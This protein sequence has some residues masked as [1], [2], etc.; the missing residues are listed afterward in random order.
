MILGTVNRISKSTGSEFGSSGT[1][2]DYSGIR[3]WKQRHR[4]STPVEMFE[5]FRFLILIT[6][7]LLLPPAFL[8]GLFTIPS[9]S[10][11]GNLPSEFGRQVADSLELRR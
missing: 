8:G 4:K 6:I 9:Q 7:F 10:V 1:G 5:E 3:I 2:N 11:V